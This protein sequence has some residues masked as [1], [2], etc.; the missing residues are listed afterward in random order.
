MEHHFFSRNNQH[1]TPNKN[2]C[3]HQETPQKNQVFS[4]ITLSHPPKILSK[5]HAL[6]VC[7]MIG[8]HHRG[9]KLHGLACLRVEDVCVIFLKISNPKNC[10][11]PNESC[12]DLP[13]HPPLITTTGGTGGAPCALREL[14][15]AN[16]ELG[17][18]TLVVRAP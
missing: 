10:F 5:T 17:V 18:E 15:S 3:F 11:S 12:W 1:S 6:R 4:P 9:R 7:L 14:P 13:T 2:R 8:P 16:G